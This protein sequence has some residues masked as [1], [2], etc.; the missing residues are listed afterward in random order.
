MSCA[1]IVFPLTSPMATSGKRRSSSLN[2][3]RA[4]RLTFRIVEA[5]ALTLESHGREPPHG[6][7]DGL[8]RL[9]L[10]DE[11]P[12]LASGEHFQAEGLVHGQHPQHV[13][14]EIMSRTPSSA[15]TLNGSGSPFLVAWTAS[16]PSCGGKAT[17]V[18]L[19]RSFSSRSSR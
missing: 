8:L 15:C 17:S 3:T 5:H 14:V 19:C 9:D 18:P 10:A 13:S 1:R 7:I 12:D 11:L 16:V 4:A 6:S 2:Q